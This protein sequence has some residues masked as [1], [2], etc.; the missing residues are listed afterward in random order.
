MVELL[1]LTV[2]PAAMALA[3][4]SDL[5]TMKIPN[6]I[7]VALIAGFCILAVATGMDLA[8]LGQHAGTAAVM[9]VFG[10]AMFSMGWVGGGDAKLFAA[11]GLWFGF[12]QMLLVY[13]IYAG[14]IGGAI[15]ILLLA[16]R[17]VPLHETALQQ[18][19]VG[20]LHS[21][22]SGVPY[23]IALAFSGLAVYVNSPWMSALAG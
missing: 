12:S 20:R 17:K 3:A 18:A 4:A 16:F 5:V 9:L 2:F 14:L 10:F 6:W 11:T 21:A 13:V 7:H 15:T 19:W 8:V 23:G 1:T 22:E